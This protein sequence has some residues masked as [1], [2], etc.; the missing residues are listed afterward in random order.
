MS[1]PGQSQSNILLNSPSDCF[2]PLQGDDGDKM[3]QVTTD[4]VDGSS[5]RRKNSTAVI[6]DTFFKLAFLKV[7]IVDI[8]ISIGKMSPNDK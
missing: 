1:P 8:G 6:V 2:T 3:S 4:E 7:L 5:S